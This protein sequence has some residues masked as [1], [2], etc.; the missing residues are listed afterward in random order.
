MR[1][2]LRLHL[3]T[4]K[5]HHEWCSRARNAY[6]NDNNENVNSNVNNSNNQNDNLGS[7]GVIRVYWLCTDFNQPPSILPISE[8]PD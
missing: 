7:R 3:T 4:D 5:L 2:W 8:A 6:W 1:I